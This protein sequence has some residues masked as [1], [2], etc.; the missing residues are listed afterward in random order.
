MVN[1]ECLPSST[2][3]NYELLSSHYRHFRLVERFSLL[4]GALCVLISGE[5][6]AHGDVVPGVEF[7]HEGS[8]KMD[9]LVIV[10]YFE[11]T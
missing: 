6:D 9:Q 3:V 2:G 1:C 5:F 4:T 7:G 8:M 11:S 10:F